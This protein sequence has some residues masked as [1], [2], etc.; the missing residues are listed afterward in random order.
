MAHRCPSSTKKLQKKLVGKRCENSWGGAKYGKFTKNFIFIFYDSFFSM[1]SSEE[2]AKGLWVIG[3]CFPSA[4][5]VTLGG[6]VKVKV[7]VKPKYF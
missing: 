5:M 3:K 1:R 6:Q 4:D 2:G 7:Q